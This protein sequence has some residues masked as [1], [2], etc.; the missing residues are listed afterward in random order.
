MVVLMSINYADT[1]SMYYNFANKYPYNITM[2]KPWKFNTHNKD[3]YLHY[4]YL[5]TDKIYFTFY[6]DMYGTGRLFVV[7]SLPKLLNGSNTYNVKHFDEDRCY[8]IISNK[9]SVF[10]WVILAPYDKPNSFHD[11]IAS[12][13]DLFVMHQIPAGKREDYQQAYELLTLPRYRAVKY[14][15]TC[16]LNSSFRPDKK[17]NKVFR[18][19]PKIKEIQD[20]ICAEYPLSVHRQ[21][22]I[23]LQT[24]DRLEDLYRF[25]FMLR[26][27]CI[28]YE[29]KKRNIPSTM[30]EVLQPDFQKELL[31]S[32]ISAVGLDRQI[33]RTT[34]FQKQVQGIFKTQ[35]SK[36]NALLLAR[37]IRNKRTIPLTAN[38]IYRIK[39]ELKKQNIH[40]VTH[41]YI[42]LLPVPLPLL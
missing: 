26:R 7:F 39:N 41:R 10:P 5:K 21:H 31:S 16:Y 6:P 25:E 15:N 36:S 27:Q 30:H 32:M 18:A 1:I 23:Y 9:L 33:L 35:K 11:W 2:P 12:R 38:Q 17:S 42:N 13:I 22:E 3:A 8:Q 20:R 40:F 14:K 19:Y 37:C 28:I 24:M 4:W 29:C 34:E